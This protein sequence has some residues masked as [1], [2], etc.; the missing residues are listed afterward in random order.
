MEKVCVCVQITKAVISSETHLRLCQLPQSIKRNKL[1]YTGTCLLK[2]TAATRSF[3]AT[4]RLS[5]VVSFRI[6]K[7]CRPKIVFVEP[8]VNR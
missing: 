4:A 8:M 3:P 6:I 7:T 2:F 5:L 1:G